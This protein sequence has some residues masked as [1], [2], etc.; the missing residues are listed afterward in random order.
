MGVSV[1]GSKGRRMARLGFFFFLRNKTKEGG[2]LATRL[3]NR[4]LSCMWS[5]IRKSPIPSKHL[6]GPLWMWLGCPQVPKQWAEWNIGCFGFVGNA[7][8]Q[9]DT[10]T[11]KCF[12]NYRAPCK[13]G[14]GELNSACLHND[15]DLHELFCTPEWAWCVHGVC[16]G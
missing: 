15:M 11:Y 6:A 13:R 1:H 16:R 14:V 12:V 2:I 10:R 8:T 9:A 7:V 4:A 5:G 3:Q